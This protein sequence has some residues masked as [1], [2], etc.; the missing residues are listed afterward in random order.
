MYSWVHFF[1]SSGFL[2]SMKTQK[3]T[4]ELKVLEEEFLLKHSGEVGRDC[5]CAV[6]CCKV[7]ACA[8]Y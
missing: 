2:A 8:R 5:A 6:K 3:K 7:F 4:A 1:T